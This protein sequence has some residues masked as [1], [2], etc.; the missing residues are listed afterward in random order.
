MGVGKGIWTLRTHDGKK[1]CRI[2]PDTVSVPQMQVQFLLMRAR[3]NSRF[4][5][6]LLPSVD[7]KQESD[8]S[9]DKNELL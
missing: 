7:D 3:S 6:H 1:Q 4:H 5:P 2:H 8:P 9:V